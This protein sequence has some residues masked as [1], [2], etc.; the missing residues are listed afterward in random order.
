MRAFWIGLSVAMLAGSSF[1]D[2]S[3]MATRFGNTTITRDASGIERHVYFKADGT[4]TGKR[5]AIKFSGTWKLKTGM[6]CLT[7]A[8]AV[9]GIPNP[10]CAPV[11]AHKVGDR[12]KTGPNT[13]S[14]VAGI[15]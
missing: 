12:W 4:F 3:V 8:I 5:G 2:D 6:I 14:L 13:T 10:A 7:T 9:P 1:A 15:Q 11:S